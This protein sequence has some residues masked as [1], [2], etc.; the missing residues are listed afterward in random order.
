MMTS[1]MHRRSFEGQHLIHFVL[2]NISKLN[3][4]SFFII[5]SLVFIS[6]KQKLYKFNL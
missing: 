3:V 2:K 6:L 4:A 5:I 1:G